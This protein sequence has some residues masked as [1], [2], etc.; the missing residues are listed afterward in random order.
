MIG[1][2]N[3]ART[4]RRQTAPAGADRA[5]ASRGRLHR[6]AVIVILA[7]AVFLFAPAMFG[8]G[9]SAGSSGV[10]ASSPSLSVD[11]AAR[12]AVAELVS[13]P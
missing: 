9:L 10:K 5:P 4:D 6:D 13:R 12:D 1:I 7:V 2:E 11:A 3:V 8:V